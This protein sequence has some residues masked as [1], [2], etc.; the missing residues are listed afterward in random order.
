MAY[1]LKLEREFTVWCFY[2]D[3][4]THLSISLALFALNLSLRFHS[5]LEATRI[6]RHK[7]TNANLKRNAIKSNGLLVRCLFQMNSTTF[8]TNQIKTN[9][10]NEHI[11]VLND[12]SS[13][14][15]K[16]N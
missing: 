2:M 12:E 13:F 14:F 16:Q 8:Y 3:R 5:A 9:L 1:L 15:S 11:Q 7:S 6:T 10:K 4:R